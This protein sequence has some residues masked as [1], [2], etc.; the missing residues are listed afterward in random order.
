MT[1]DVFCFV[2][3]PFV[4]GF[5]GEAQGE[6]AAARPATNLAA[7]PREA[8]ARL[9]QAT[10]F[11]QR[12]APPELN[13]NYFNRQHPGKVIVAYILSSKKDKYTL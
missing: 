13:S 1:D 7:D 3:C 4:V 8:R 9:Q 5:V 2:G 11:P 6:A 10:R 12:G